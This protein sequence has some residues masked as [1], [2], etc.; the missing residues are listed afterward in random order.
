MSSLGAARY[1]L[2]ETFRRSGVGVA[3]PVWVVAS[4]SDLLVTTRA[5][6]GKVKR[7]RYSGRVTLV[8][9]DIRGVVADGAVPIEGTAVVDTSAATRA[10]LDALMEEKY[11]ERFREMRAAASARPVAPVSVALRISI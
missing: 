9:C 3:T 10:E 6:S 11:G 4:G 2:L 7:I 8:E 1:V 5:E